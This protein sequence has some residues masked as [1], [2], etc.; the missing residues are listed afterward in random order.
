MFRTAAIIYNMDIMVITMQILSYLKFIF[1][2]T[3]NN[4]PCK[5]TLFTLVENMECKKMNGMN[6][7]KHVLTC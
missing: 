2:S 7:R 4:K 3:W 6:Y 5:H 1:Y